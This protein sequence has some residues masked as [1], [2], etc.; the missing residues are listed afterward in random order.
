[1]LAGW[2]LAS[3]LPPC[4]SLPSYPP[5]Q[6]KIA[7]TEAACHFGLPDGAA[8]VAALRA[9]GAGAVLRDADEWASWSRMGDPVLHIEL[10]RWAD[11]VVFAPLGA[12]AL[13]KLANGLCDNL[14]TCVARVG[15]SR[16][17]Q[18]LA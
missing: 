15:G 6:V 8:S 3:P 11:V 13:A 9:A 10:R 7:L 18:Q 1:M 14:V 5:P 16:C 4:P 17:G 12:N 2:S